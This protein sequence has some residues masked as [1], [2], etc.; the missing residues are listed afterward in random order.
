MSTLSNNFLQL[1]ISKSLTFSGTVVGQFV[2]QSKNKLELSYKIEEQLHMID[3]T[4]VK[5]P[6][7]EMLVQNM[8]GKRKLKLLLS[9]N[10]E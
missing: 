2:S 4:G 8:E 6:D 9:Q 1:D 3:T 10:H 7:R 5:C